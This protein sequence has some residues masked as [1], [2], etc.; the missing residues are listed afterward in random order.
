VTKTT[1]KNILG[2]STHYYDAA[3]ALLSDGEIVAVAQEVRFTRK[4]H[5]AHF[6]RQAIEYID[7]LLHLNT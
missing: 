1:I 4:K 6:P 5:D 7:N 3:A 2:I